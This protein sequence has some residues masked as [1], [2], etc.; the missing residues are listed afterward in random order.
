MSWATLPPELR[1]LAQSV[2]TPKELEALRLWDAGAG[3]RRVGLMLDISPST[4][5]DRVQ[6]ALRKMERARRG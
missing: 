1:E 6:R 5:R 3:Y 4:A 2:C